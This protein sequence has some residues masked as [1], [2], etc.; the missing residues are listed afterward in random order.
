M[1]VNLVDVLVQIVA[2]VESFLADG[3]LIRFETLVDAHVSVEVVLL[4]EQTVTDV[5]FVRLFA[6]VG[7]DV[8]F[9]VV[10]LN[11]LFPAVWTVERLR[12]RMDQRVTTEL[13]LVWKRTRT[14]RT[15]KRILKDVRLHM[16]L[17]VVRL[18]KCFLT[19]LA[20]MGFNL[21]VL[22]HVIAHVVLVH[23]DLVAHGTNVWL[24]IGIAN[25]DVFG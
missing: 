15:F 25:S 3:A 21:V 1:T 5:A 7:P 16:G 8:R 19:D 4:V 12:R 23:K 20:F 9:K 13:F 10:R 17:Q 18:G 11:E 22:L 2:L 24:L 14:E 6:G